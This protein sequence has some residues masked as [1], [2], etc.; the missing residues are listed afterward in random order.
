MRPLAILHTPSPV[1]VLGTPVPS[2]KWSVGS[3]FHFTKP[4]RARWCR[5]WPSP[6]IMP[7]NRAFTSS[8]VKQM[9]LKSVVYCMS[10]SLVTLKY[11]PG[12]YIFWSVVMRDSATMSSLLF[13]R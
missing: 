6:S 3:V 8:G 1:P 11:V 7:A 10:M 2:P 4:V 9:P 12:K 13:S 5:V